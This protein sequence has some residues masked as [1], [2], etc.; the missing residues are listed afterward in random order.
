M[1]PYEE[2]KKDVLR[3]ACH[4]LSHLENANQQHHGEEGV[5]MNVHCVKPLHR[6]LRTV[7][8]LDP[9]VL[10]HEVPDNRRNGKT[11]QKGEENALDHRFATCPHDTQSVHYTTE[12]PGTNGPRI[13]H[14][15]ELKGRA[16]RRST[17]R[18][19]EESN[20]NKRRIISCP[21]V[22]RL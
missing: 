12:A 20:E 8:P 22:A 5:E 13:R 6:L 18:H 14:R 7:G 21:L 11:T 2:G 10:V 3:I 17:Y 16:G 15:N 4:S 1:L 19:K 9:H